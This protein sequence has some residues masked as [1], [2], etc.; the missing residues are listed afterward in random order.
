MRKS[1]SRRNTAI[2]MASCA[3]VFA[4]IG[5]LLR[6]CAGSIGPNT[7]SEGDAELASAAVEVIPDEG[8][9]A[10]SIAEVTP[11]DTR[12][13]TIGAPLDGTFEIGSVSKAMTGLLYADA[14]DRGEVSPESTLGEIF[15]L[16]DAAAAKVTLEELSQHHSGLPV[17]PW[18]W[19]QLLNNYRWLLL[20]QNPYRDT[21]SSV[22]EDLRTISV[23]AKEPV[24]SNLGFAALGH[25]L[26]AAAG[27]DYP[28]L[29]ETRLA[30]PLN[31]E[32]FYVPPPGEGDADPQAVQGRE[33]SGRAQQAWDDSGYAPTGGI[34]ADA[35]SM[36]LL[37]TALLDGSAPGIEALDPSAEFDG[38]D[39]IGAGW[40][41]SQVEGHDVTWHNG[42]TGGFAT[43]FGLHRETGTAVFIS[44]AT[45]QPLDAA[46][47]ALL[48][49]AIEQS[50][51]GD[52]Q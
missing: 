44:G 45:N 14:V 17:L 1:S 52:Q 46:G 51:G 19:A 26:G 12:I 47:H 37:A 49:S 24:Y 7:D 13:S 40:F 34:R 48:L 9:Y 27:T 18:G 41:T 25:A 10:L 32:A 30:N 4:V 38:G 50:N 39:Q 42:M 22:V 20:A 35:A 36:A 3:V 29:I 11:D 6:P 8:V 21:P 16:G 5:V 43:W 28:S 15:D 2:V 23:G 33:A 31:L